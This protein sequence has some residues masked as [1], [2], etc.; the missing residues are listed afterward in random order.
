M[1]K[2]NYFFLLSFLVISPAIYAKTKQ[3]QLVPQQ[4]CVFMVSSIVMISMMMMMMM[5][6][7]MEIVIMMTTMMMIAL[8]MTM[9]I[10]KM[11]ERN[12]ERKA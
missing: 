8:I 2:I 11:K 12:K 10:M 9:T 5:M 4:H 1:N 7:M 3:I 6:M